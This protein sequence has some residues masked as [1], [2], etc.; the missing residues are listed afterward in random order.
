MQQFVS[1]SA[2]EAR[3]KEKEARKKIK[4]DVERIRLLTPRR[5]YDLAQKCGVSE[6]MMRHIIGEEIK[7]A[8]I[9]W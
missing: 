9:N 5:I 6:L 7:N 2:D 1:G 8:V 3:R 4:K